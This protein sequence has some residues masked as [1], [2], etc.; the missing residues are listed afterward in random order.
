VQREI[1][2]KKQICTKTLFQAIQMQLTKMPA[3]PILL[4]LAVESVLGGACAIR[5]K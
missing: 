5:R 4:L 1:K 2:S 3:N